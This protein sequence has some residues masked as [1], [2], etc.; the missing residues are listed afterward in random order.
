VSFRGQNIPAMMAG[1]L[2]AGDF[3]FLGVQAR[4]VARSVPGSL[5][6]PAAE[7]D[8]AAPQSIHY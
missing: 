7:R 8:P 6:G 3:V 4:V 2:T 5:P 1:L